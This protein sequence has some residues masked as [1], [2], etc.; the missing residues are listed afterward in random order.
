MLLPLNGMFSLETLH[1]EDNN[2]AD[3]LKVLYL[4]S[5]NLTDISPLAGL[6]GLEEL[7]IQDN[8]GITDFSP[9]AGLKNTKIER[10][11]SD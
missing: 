11:R 3:N 6:K 9:L 2:I 5:N 4:I 7:H 1:L 8:I 10:D